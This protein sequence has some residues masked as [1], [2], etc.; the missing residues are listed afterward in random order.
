MQ[1]IRIFSLFLSFFPLTQDKVISTILFQYL[2]RQ[3]EPGRNH[4]R[5]GE[6]EAI[7]PPNKKLNLGRS[8]FDLSIGTWNIKHYCGSW[9]S[10]NIFEKKLDIMR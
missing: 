2:L 1:L 5:S 9:F 6:E 3:G 4:E 8:E 7:H 10:N